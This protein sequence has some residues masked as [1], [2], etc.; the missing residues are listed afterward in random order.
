MSLKHGI[1]GLIDYGPM[2][3]Y[4]LCKV[5]NESLAFFWQAT[6]SQVYRELAAMEKAGWLTSNE[7]VQSGKP[8]KK[9][10]TLTDAGRAEL[11][12]W[13]SNPLVFA[14]VVTRHTFLM[15]LFFAS[16]GNRETA[17]EH[18]VSFRDMNRTYLEELASSSA[19]E[20]YEK[21]IPQSGAPVYWALTAQ[22]GLDYYRMCIS[23]ADDAIKK[24]T[25]DEQ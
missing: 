12:A 4:E 15:K 9:L 7:V 20:T 17:L 25:E 3:G 10:Y 14:D 22:F 13:V 24:L 18:L 19:I 5:F 21:D 11:G 16:A 6:T 8:N 1:L 23:W 2:T